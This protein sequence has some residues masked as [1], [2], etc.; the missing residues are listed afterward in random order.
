MMQLAKTKRNCK[1]S[2]FFEDLNFLNPRSHLK[3]KDLNDL[4]QFRCYA[5]VTKKYTVQFRRYG[6]YKNSINVINLLC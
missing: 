5:E 3:V 1:I 6:H 4:N 2:T